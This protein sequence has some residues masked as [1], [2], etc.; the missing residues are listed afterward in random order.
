MGALF[1]SHVVV[2]NRCS[3]NE[4][5]TLPVAVGSSIRYSASDAGG[6]GPL[7]DDPDILPWSRALWMPR[8]GD[9]KI[10]TANMKLSCPG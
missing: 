3:S 4:T 10:Q 1:D 8:C 6:W 7:P 2:L 5:S 9:Q